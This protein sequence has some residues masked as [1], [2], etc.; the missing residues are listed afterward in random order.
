ME[1]NISVNQDS[2]TDLVALV[3][4]SGTKEKLIEVQSLK[5]GL[6]FLYMLGDSEIFIYLLIRFSG[7]LL[8]PLEIPKTEKTFEERLVLKAFLLKFVN[9]YAS[10]FYVAFFKG[11]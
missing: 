7:L 2:V 9:S 8:F 11:R 6:V 4:I 5:F 1:L 10:I 3:Q